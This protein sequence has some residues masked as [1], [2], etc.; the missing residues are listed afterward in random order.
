[1]TIDV[2]TTDERELLRETVRRF[3]AER[4]PIAYVR[5]MYDDERGTTD[6]LWQGLAGLGLTGILVPERHGGLGLGLADMG[7]VLEEMGRALLPGP[8]LSSAV[9]ATLALQAAGSEADAEYL[10]PSLAAG[11]RVATLALFEPGRRYEWR[12]PDTRAQATTDG[13]TLQGTKVHVPDGAAADVLLVAAR[14]PDDDLA[15]FAVERVHAAVDAEPVLDGTRKQA[16]IV[17]DA[18]PARRLGTGDATEALAG[19]V[20]RLCVAL[21][22]DAVGAGQAAL[23]ICLSYARDRTAFGRPIGSFQAVQHLCVAMYQALELSRA[24][25]ARGLGEA[26][27]GDPAELHRVALIAKTYASDAMVELA[28]NAIQV[29]GGIGTTWEHDIHLFYKRCLSMQAAYGGSLELTDILARI[30]ID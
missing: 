27:G 8:F 22:V 4:A 19:V 7:V 24:A 16:T 21:V 17:L 14:T 1:M 10:L 30:I 29:H 6:A 25:A 26:D 15:L 13:W 11:E 12:R 20:D 18:V 9:A 5:E 2:S 3:L 28:N 23:E